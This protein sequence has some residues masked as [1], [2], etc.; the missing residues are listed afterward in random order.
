MSD[1]EDLDID[2]IS[3]NV[4]KIKKI[5]SGAK[6]K[7]AERA[8]VHILNERFDA[9]LSSHPAW[10]KFSRSV[11]SGNRWGQNVDLPKHA[12]DTFSGDLCVPQNFKWVIESKKGYNDIDLVSAFGG[13][14]SGLDEFIEQ[15]VADAERCGRHP[16]LLWK[17]DRKSILAVIKKFWLGPPVEFKIHMIYNDWIIVSFDELIKI[18]PDAFFFES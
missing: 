12:K 17:K 5:K 15:V 1:Y 13:K 6:G 18:M 3:K 8:I 9:L 14:C 11:G 10:G 16:M 2:D 7:S 4:E